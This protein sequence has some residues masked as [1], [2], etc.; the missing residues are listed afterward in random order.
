MTIRYTRLRITVR[1][2]FIGLAMA[3]LVFVA[4]QEQLYMAT[5]LS[6]LLVAGLVVELWYFL[7]RVNRDIASFLTNI[8][9]KDLTISYDEK[10]SR[11]ELY[12]S[13]NTVIKEIRD[14]RIDKE[15]HYQFLQTIISLIKT[16]LISFD[17]EGNIFLKNL[18]AGQYLPHA[19]TSKI[20]GVREVN[21]GLFAVIT[22]MKP[23]ENELLKTKM[24]DDLVQLSIFATEFKMKGVA[25][26][27]VSIQNISSEMENQEIDAYHKLIR[28]LTHEIMNS[29]TPISSLSTA[30]TEMLLK[31][32][33]NRRELENLDDEEREDLFNSLNAIEKRSKGLIR[34]VS[35][36]KN[37]TRVPVPRVTTIKIKDLFSGIKSLLGHVIEDAG[38]VLIFR[39]HDED[40]SIQADREMIERVLINLVK[41]AAEAI[42]EGGQKGRIELFA[43]KQVARVFIRVKDNGPGIPQTETDKLFVPFYTTKKTGSGIGLSLCRNMMKA[44]KG[45]ISFRSEPGK[46]TEFILEF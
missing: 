3:L 32:N 15:A 1:V 45:H 27:L 26:K 29:V 13:F 11:S 38:I 40:L 23:G 12:S 6:G 19:A 44:N 10:K 25:Y 42:E 39:L 2:L 33:G 8:V 34:F 20:S 16:A 35:T 30:M 46:G 22:Q 36:Y 41:N 28:V 21:P 37:I 7:D 5:F 4:H 9:H 17:N 43:E 18:A 14:A 24:G 31:N